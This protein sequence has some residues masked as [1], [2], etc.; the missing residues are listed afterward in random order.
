MGE[1]KFVFSTE[2]LPRYRFPTHT[3]D[4]IIDRSQA[5]VSEV[6]MVIMEPGEAP[7]LHKHDDAEQVFYV[8]QG[9]GTL[10][11]GNDD[12][13]LFFNISPGDVVRV[14]PCTWHLARCTSSIAL[15]YLSVDCFVNPESL[16]EDT[17]DSHVEV[18]C[19]NFGWDFNQVKQA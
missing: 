17:W 6:F 19:N 7:P 18:M 10:Q 3:N 2:N 5:A 1:A 16:K 8:L 13:P 12:A 9:E 11:I 14:P 4:L 15:K